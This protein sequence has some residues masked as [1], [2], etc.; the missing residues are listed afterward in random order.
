MFNNK[1]CYSQSMAKL[2]DANINGLL[3]SNI[4]LILKPNREYKIKVRASQWKENP[5]FK[6]K[7]LTDRTLYNFIGISICQTNEI[8]FKRGCSNLTITYNGINDYLL[9]RGQPIAKFSITEKHKSPYNYRI[10]TIPKSN[11][12]S[13]DYSIDTLF[14]SDFD[15]EIKPKFPK[16]M[17]QINMCKYNYCS[18]QQIIDVLPIDF[19]PIRK[20]ILVFHC[21]MVK[22]LYIILLVCLLRLCV[23]TKTLSIWVKSVKSMKIFYLFKCMVIIL[24]YY[25]GSEMIS[26]KSNCLSFLKSIK[27]IERPILS[28]VFLINRTLA[29]IIL[30]FLSV[31]LYLKFDR[32]EINNVIYPISN[33]L[34]NTLNYNLV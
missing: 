5:S 24:A 23:Y 28:K 19:K 14:S 20:L 4:N 11:E 22:G 31:F 3:H 10:K 34:V 25:K 12:I 16:I 17:P 27:K 33:F 6:A 7:A 30:S 32:S 29:L 21:Y 8:I 9:V 2:S 15:S 13:D 18:D 1:V 26:L